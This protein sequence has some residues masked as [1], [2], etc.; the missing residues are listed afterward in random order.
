M[1]LVDWDLCGRDKYKIWISYTNIREYMNMRIIYPWYTTLG[2]CPL[3]DRSSSGSWMY[4]MFFLQVGTSYIDLWD[5]FPPSWVLIRYVFCICYKSYV[6]LYKILIRLTIIC[7]HLTPRVYPTM[8][9][10]V[11][12]NAILLE[13]LEY[14][15]L[16]RYLENNLKS[17][18]F[19]YTKVLFVFSKSKHLQSA[20]HICNP[21]QQKRWTKRLQS[22]RRR[23][24]FNVCRL[25]A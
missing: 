5:V 4:M 18:Y 2:R 25:L 6:C 23:L 3:R 11:Q 19:L 9:I 22:A 17:K 1:L 13:I 20:D 12:I 14:K 8:L 24:F 7:T 21:L 10:Y 15:K 16:K